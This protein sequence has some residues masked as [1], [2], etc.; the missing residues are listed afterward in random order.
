[1]HIN[2]ELL[3]LRAFLA[4]YEL[5]SFR[6]AADLLH[7]SQ[8]ALSRRVQAIEGKLQ[9]SLFERSTRHVLPTAAG[10][11][12]EPMARRLLEELDTVVSAI[13]GGGDRQSGLITIAALPSAASHFLPQLIKKF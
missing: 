11:T 1:M 2:L 12:F 5:R 10:R 4:V 9:A 6:E 7:L 13:G 8:P 3:D